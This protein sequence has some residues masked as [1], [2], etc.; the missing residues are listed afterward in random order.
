MALL[1][2]SRDNS[3]SHPN[4]EKFNHHLHGTLLKTKTA[5]SID[6]SIIA[7]IVAAQKSTIVIVVEPSRRFSLPSVA[8]S[9]GSVVIYDF[10]VS[11]SDAS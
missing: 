10:E 5:G 9:F 4:C 2:G 7:T 1:H 6:P 8:R 3:I 11:S